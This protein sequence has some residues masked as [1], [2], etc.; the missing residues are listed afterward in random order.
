M[1][2]KDFDNNVN[3]FRYKYEGLQKKIISALKERPLNI[4]ELRE[5]I[6]DDDIG[7]SGQLQF[8][9]RKGNLFNKNFS[10]TVYWALP[11]EDR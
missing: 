2:Y 4:F 8:L 5:I 6:K 1:N 7:L 9:K 10:G 11:K 3:P